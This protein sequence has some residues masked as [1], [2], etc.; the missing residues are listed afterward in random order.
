MLLAFV[1]NVSFSIVSRSRNRNNMK[2]HLIASIFS[3]G[4]WFVTFRA[5]V[6]SQMNLL[7]FP[8]YTA[9]TVAGSLCGAW[10]S[11]RIEAWLGAASD[12]HLKRDR[13]G[14]LAARLEQLEVALRFPPG[15]PRS[16]SGSESSR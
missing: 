4:V 5:L 1:Q 16:A 9:G 14:E 2:Y 11:M 13:M 7:L 10:V 12:D 8:F 6:T 15:A 3:N